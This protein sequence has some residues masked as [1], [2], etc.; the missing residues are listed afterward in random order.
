MVTERETEEEELQEAIRM[1]LQHREGTPAPS[2][3]PP[4]HPQHDTAAS[5]TDRDMQT[6]INRS[7]HD[8]DPSSS[9][10][11][12]DAPPPPFNPVYTPQIQPPGPG[13]P[14]GEDSAPKL[15]T[16]GG[17]AV[18]PLNQKESEGEPVRRR[19]VQGDVGG[20]EGDTAAAVRAARLRRFDKTN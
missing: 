15:P 20:A 8:T 7:L 13:R 19:H 17:R 14:R 10:P 9:L 18:L 4:S 16:S 6:A 11:T 5:N 2:A 12:S 1:S 3:P